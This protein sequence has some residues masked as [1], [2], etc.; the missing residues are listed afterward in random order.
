[1]IAMGL[2]V[3]SNSKVFYTVIEETATDYEYRTISHISI[4]SALTAPDQ[5]SYLRNTLLDI[6]LEFQVQSA[7]IRISEHTRTMKATTIQRIYVEGVI[8]ET[9]ASGNISN[10]SLGRITTIGRLLSFES[11]E[12][13]ELAS[14]KKDYAH[15]PKTWSWDEL[16]LESRE[17][18]LACHAALNL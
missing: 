10:Y 12:F 1:M 17:S 15:L 16:S 2:R 13:K 6:I 14:G 18:V 8:L 9:L 11:G 7:F 5:L 4:P 3:F